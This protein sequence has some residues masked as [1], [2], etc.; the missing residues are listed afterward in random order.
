MLAFIDQIALF[1]LKHDLRSMSEG[2]R[3]RSIEDNAVEVMVVAGVLLVICIVLLLIG[4][5]ARR[6]E[7]LK[8]YD[9]QAEL[10]RELCRARRARL[11]QPTVA[12]TPRGG[13][14]ALE[15]RVLVCR[16]GTVQRSHSARGL[17]TE[18]G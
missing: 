9:S 2:F 10:F 13:V 12:E 16:A 4:R 18:S 17:E 1:A 8:S 5:D 3:S 15:P 6:F 11:A 14:G 7:N